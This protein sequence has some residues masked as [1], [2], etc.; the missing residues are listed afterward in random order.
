MNYY[1]KI[2]KRISFLIDKNLILVDNKYI[3]NEEHKIYKNNQG[4][5]ANVYF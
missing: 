4:G 3:K 5:K 2:S 1:K